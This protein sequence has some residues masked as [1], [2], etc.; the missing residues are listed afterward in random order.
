MALCQLTPF[1]I[2]RY[3]VPG[4]R[5]GWITVH[6]RHGALVNVRHG[7]RNLAQKI[8]G[9]CAVI[10]GALPDI[11]TNTPTAFFENTA[12]VLSANAAIVYDTLSGIYMTTVT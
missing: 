7:L 2:C 9:P 10:Q 4:W 12:K 11:L 6:D 1:S 8:V 5:L 3:L